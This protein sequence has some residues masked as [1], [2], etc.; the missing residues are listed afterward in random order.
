MSGPVSTD[1]VVTCGAEPPADVEL[2]ESR[3]ATVGTM[4][5]QRVLPVG[6]PLATP[7]PKM[8]LEAGAAAAGPG[9]QLDRPVPFPQ[10]T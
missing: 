2:V 7:Y 9:Q 3:E 8:P 10:R 6:S 5:V 4:T 1:S